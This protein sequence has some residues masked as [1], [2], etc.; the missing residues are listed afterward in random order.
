MCFVRHELKETHVQEGEKIA[1]VRVFF[2]GGRRKEGISIGTPW[3]NGRTKNAGDKEEPG[4][5]VLLFR[6]LSNSKIL[7]FC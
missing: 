1:D 3:R 2:V 7:R 4:L 5:P 6:D